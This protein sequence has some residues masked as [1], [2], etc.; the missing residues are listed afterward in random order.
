MSPIKKQ[1]VIGIVG[2]ESTGKS[3]LA[4][5]LSKQYQVNFVHEIAREYLNQ[6]G[7]PYQEEDLKKNC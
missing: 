3:T 5:A 7:S 1:F 2:P 4:D 6:L